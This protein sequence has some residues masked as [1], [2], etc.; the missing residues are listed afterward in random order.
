[1]HT[2]LCVT[3][4]FS[5]SYID[6]SMELFFSHEIDHYILACSMTCSIRSTRFFLMKRDQL[7]SNLS[8]I[9]VYERYSIWHHVCLWRTLLQK[10]ACECN[11]GSWYYHNYF[12]WIIPF[13]VVWIIIYLAPCVQY[14]KK[15]SPLA[16][17]CP[18]I[19][20]CSVILRSIYT[21]KLWNYFFF[22]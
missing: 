17:V 1:M 5:Y 20:L 15:L 13:S 6:G 11:Y 3:V 10:S 8:E 18:N 19:C 22:L 21:R 4:R 14:T 16:S 12:K 9:V 7:S 2:L